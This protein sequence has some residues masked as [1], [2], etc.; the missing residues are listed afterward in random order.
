MTSALGSTSR[1]TSLSTSH[2]RRKAACSQA[3]LLALTS[4]RTAFLEVA[5]FAFS[6]VLIFP[7]SFVAFVSCTMLLCSKLFVQALPSGI[8]IVALFGESLTETFVSSAALILVDSLMFAWRALTSSMLA[9][10]LALISELIFL[11]AKAT[12]L[13]F[14]LRSEIILSF[15]C[16]V[17]ATGKSKKRGGGSRILCLIVA[18]RGMS[19]DL[20]IDFLGAV[21]A[22]A[23]SASASAVFF[24]QR[25]FRSQWKSCRA[26][27][28]TVFWT[29]FGEEPLLVRLTLR[30]RSSSAASLRGTFAS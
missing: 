4:G 22:S 19:N 13:G 21:L 2:T 3:V 23:I 16:C 7:A 11:R 9:L 6:T 10:A 12:F 17:A 25:A 15:P 18:L 1:C 24:V 8:A 14:T 30:S 28:W 5:S 20:R 29:S 27:D 26:K